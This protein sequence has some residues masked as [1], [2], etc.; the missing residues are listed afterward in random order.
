MTAA[1]GVTERW[2]RIT[3]VYL[4]GLSRGSE[5]ATANLAS[6]SSQL[7]AVMSL[8]VGMLS[9]VCDG[10]VGFWGARPNEY[11]GTPWQQSLAGI[12]RLNVLGGSPQESTEPPA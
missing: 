12:T 6:R 11:H 8:A 1:C 10:D 9:T 7:L 5:A 2:A 3:R 4:R